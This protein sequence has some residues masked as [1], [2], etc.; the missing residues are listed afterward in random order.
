MMNEL[1][2]QGIDT[3]IL[4]A[5]LQSLSLHSLSLKDLCTSHCADTI[6]IHSRLSFLQVPV[7]LWEERKIVGNHRMNLILF[8][9]GKSTAYILTSF[10]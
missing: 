10:L 5:Q 2:T 3:I 7:Q 6:Q 8:S 1:G 4:K 9:V